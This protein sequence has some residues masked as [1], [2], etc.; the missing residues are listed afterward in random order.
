MRS[1][2]LQLNHSNLQVQTLSS[3]EADLREQVDAL[4]YTI[5][6]VEQDKLLL[7]AKLQEI[8]GFEGSR[9]NNCAISLRDVRG[10]LLTVA[11]G[12]ITELSR[13]LQKCQ[14]AA[15]SQK[16]TPSAEL[17]RVAHENQALHEEVRRISEQLAQRTVLY[18]AQERRYHDTTRT[19]GSLQN[20]KDT[21]NIQLRARLQQLEQQYERTDRAHMEAVLQTRQQDETNKRLLAQLTDAMEKARTLDADVADLST[22]NVSLQATVDRLRGADMDE[23][24]R[25]LA[26]EVEVIRAEG[27]VRE[28]ALRRQL[29]SARD[30]MQTEA[31]RRERLVDEVERLRRDLSEQ[32]SVLREAADRGLIHSL[33]GFDPAARQETPLEASLTDAEITHISGGRRRDVD[34]SPDNSVFAAMFG[35]LDEAGVASE[36]AE[37]SSIDDCA[38]QTRGG[39]HHRYHGDDLS[40]DTKERHT[41]SANMDLLLPLVASTALRAVHSL[42]REFLGAFGGIDDSLPTETERK[43]L[44]VLVQ[45]SKSGASDSLSQALWGD[46]KALTIEAMQRADKFEAR[47]DSHSRDVLWEGVTRLLVQTVALFPK[48]VGVTVVEARGLGKDDASGNGSLSRQFLTGAHSEDGGT[49]ESSFVSSNSTHNAPTSTEGLLREELAALKEELIRRKRRELK[50]LAAFK[51]QGQKLALVIKRASELQ[52]PLSS[53][54]SSSS[55]SSSSSAS[56]IS[57]AQRQ[58]ENEE[59]L[60]VQA[61][62]SVLRQQVEG[63]REEL[64]CAESQAESNRQLG[65]HEAAEMYSVSVRQLEQEVRDLKAA[66]GETKRGEQSHASCQADASFVEAPRELSPSVPSAE[67]LEDLADMREQV[68]IL[69]QALVDSCSELERIQSALGKSRSRQVQP[70]PSPQQHT[71]QPCEEYA[72]QSQGGVVSASD[73]HSG[74]FASAL[75]HAVEDEEERRVMEATLKNHLELWDERAEM[76]TSEQT[77]ILHKLGEAQSSLA[78]LYAKHEEDKRQALAAQRAALDASHDDDMASLRCHH[79]DEVHDLISRLQAEHAETMTS[80]TQAMQLQL[81]RLIA[82]L[83]Q[84]HRHELLQLEASCAGR[85]SQCTSAEASTL[86]EDDAA[87]EAQ[88]ETVYQAKLV[89]LRGLYEEEMT[90]ALQLLKGELQAMHEDKLCQLVRKYRGKLQRQEASFVEERDQLLSLVKQD[91]R[92]IAHESFILAEE[93]RSSRESSLSFSGRPTVS[94]TSRRK[95]ASK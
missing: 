6:S 59:F 68:R 44:S 74:S 75:S 73:D 60:R 27:K 94:K 45:L 69:K 93:V 47:S 37:T 41:K 70:Q 46:A 34:A 18:A 53:A 57:S 52:G 11:N 19:F 2:E 5:A 67:V 77:V 43:L 24:E 40:D 86:T 33:H 50:L 72:P 82:S 3:R 26:A 32:G 78:A 23:L 16:A 39:Q 12:K 28:D 55:S 66:R 35:A 56:S 31:E 10:K 15:E 22:Q 88:Y 79:R 71:A 87:R 84:D 8:A 1:L 7:E 4:Q 62:V 51:E 9:A 61:E 29:E 89:K 58:H 20:E 13:A 91:Y 90:A 81:H 36:W 14:Q 21:E 54:S 95:T 76:W 38:L 80:A 85:S 65:H 25:D 48:P 17:V 63:L 42:L 30:N 83:T 64:T 92:E 49:A